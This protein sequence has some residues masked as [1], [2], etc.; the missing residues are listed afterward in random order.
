MTF[1]EAAA[2]LSLNNN[3]GVTD[4]WNSTPAWG[5]PYQGSGLAPSPAA[6]TLIEGGLAAEVVGTNLYGYWNRLI[7]AEAGLY[8]TLS[9]RTQTIW[10]C[11]AL[12]SRNRRLRAPAEACRKLPAMSL[13]RGHLAPSGVS[14]GLLP[15]RQ[16]IVSPVQRSRCAQ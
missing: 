15:E 12:L 9:T 10:P 7:Y 3:P 1:E 4:V 14:P 6:G 13:R 8:K 2:T 5:Y 11:P 16:W